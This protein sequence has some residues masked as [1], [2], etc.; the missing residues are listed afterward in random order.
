[1]I[2]SRYTSDKLNNDTH[3]HTHTYQ[4]TS[5]GIR[6]NKAYML[7][8]QQT[9]RETLLFVASKI[10]PACKATF[11]QHTTRDKLAELLKHGL[12]SRFVDSP[13]DVK[14]APGRC[15]GCEQACR[16]HAC[17]HST[18]FY[19][20][21]ATIFMYVY[22]YRCVCRYICIC[23]NICSSM[24]ENKMHTHV[25]QTASVAQT[26]IHVT[27]LAG[28]GLIFTVHRLY[29][30]GSLRDLIHASA[31][32]TRYVDKYAWPGDPLVSFMGFHRKL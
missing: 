24:T 27:K 9:S 18:H 21:V 4:V 2:L 22:I 16:Y 11:M 28:E 14:F 5:M 8:K 23:T 12:R 30:Y 32:R 31:P 3:T 17:M 25:N 15:A 29:Q 1:M 7:V 10:P 13:I 19:V 26:R 6:R 20:S